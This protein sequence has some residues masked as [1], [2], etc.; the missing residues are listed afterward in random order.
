MHGTHACHAGRTTCM[1]PCSSHVLQI[2][3]RQQRLL[4]E[5]E[6]DA[7]NTDGHGGDDRV[8]MMM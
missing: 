1:S 7:D 5:R 4:N 2:I 6:C 3:V 8:L